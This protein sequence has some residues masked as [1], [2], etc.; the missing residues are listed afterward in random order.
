[1]A[2]QELGGRPV[3]ISKE[4]GKIKIVFHPIAKGA[5]HPDAT[6]FSVKLSKIDIEI[7]KKALS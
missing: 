6:V 2:K 1:M 4:D 3:D 5:K 7:L